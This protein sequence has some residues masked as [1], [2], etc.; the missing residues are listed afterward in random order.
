[1]QVVQDDKGLGS[2]VLC[3]VYVELEWHIVQNIPEQ[4][5]LAL[6]TL[7]RH[8]TLIIILF[9]KLSNLSHSLNVYA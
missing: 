2:S 3:V 5:Q 8:D 9:A 6:C 4:L 1:M 7:S